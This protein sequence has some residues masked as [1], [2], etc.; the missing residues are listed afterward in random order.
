[1][2][3]ELDRLAKEKYAALPDLKGMTQLAITNKLILWFLEQSEDV[4]ASIL[5][6]YPALAR[7]D[8]TTAILKAYISKYKRDSVA[9]ART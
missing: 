9:R 5:G 6:L 7:Y 8:V 2:R 4:Q 1:M 3:L